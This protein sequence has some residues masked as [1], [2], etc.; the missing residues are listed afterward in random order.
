MKKSLR[1][2]LIILLGSGMFKITAQNIRFEIP[3]QSTGGTDSVF[4]ENELGIVVDTVVVPVS[5][6][7]AEQEND[8]IDALNDDDLDAGWEGAPE[9]QN[10]LTMGLRFRDISI[11]RG[12]VVDS[13]FIYFSCH[14]AKASDE[15]AKITIAGNAS[16]NPETYTEDSL[17]SARP[18]TSASVYWI[19]D[20]VYDLYGKYSTPDIKSIVQELVNRE[21][22]NPGNAMAFILSGENQGPS[23]VDNAREFEAF[24]NIADPEDGGDGQNHPERVPS[25]VIYYQGNVNN[26]IE[27]NSSPEFEV[28]PN[29]VNDGILHLTNLN[30]TT[31]LSVTF[32]DVTG[33]ACQ[34]FNRGNVLTGEV[35]TFNI[36]NLSKGL[37]FVSVATEAGTFVKN[38]IVK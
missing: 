12:A 37:Y 6:D 36:G 30:Q 7:D 22:W 28:Y 16:D 29:P 23:D 9:D 27:I 4:L 35:I 5:S 14:E 24:E 15:I 19:A 11:P 38:V 31:W 2:L 10:I 32:F 3:I 26:T 20:D 21:G 1:L 34:E 17:I 18:K 8:E 33:R 13:A 25:L